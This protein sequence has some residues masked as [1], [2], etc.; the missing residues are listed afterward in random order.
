MWGSFGVPLFHP[1]EDD[2]FEG[3][4]SDSE[5]EP[6]KLQTLPL[7]EEYCWNSR[8]ELEHDHGYRTMSDLDDLW[9]D[10]ESEVLPQTDRLV[11]Q[12]G[13]KPSILVRAGE[14]RKGGLSGWL[15]R[16]RARKSADESA[17]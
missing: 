4:E 8:R 2:K 17:E 5:L 11:F 9:S 10:Y 16:K 1:E 7:V 15:A 3:D 12:G 6:D 13:G 14:V